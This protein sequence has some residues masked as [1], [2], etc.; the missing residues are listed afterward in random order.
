MKIA[1]STIV[2]AA[3]VLSL[4]SPIA[5]SAQTTPAADGSIQQFQYK[6]ALR[7]SQD[8]IGRTL[9]A[10]R[11]TDSSGRSVPLAALRGKPLVLSLVYTSCYQICPTT[12]RHL[13]RVVEKAREIVDD[14][15]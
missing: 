14:N 13:A 10:H 2:L 11:F 12:T 4:L 3:V 8:A 6:S 1:K 7:A 15:Q 9:S 5:G